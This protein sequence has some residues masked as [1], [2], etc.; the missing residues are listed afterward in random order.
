ME[1]SELVSLTKSAAGLVSLITVCLMCVSWFYYQRLA[2]ELFFGIGRDRGLTKWAIQRKLLVGDIGDLT[3][4]QV[5]AYRFSRRLFLC[6]LS[7]FAGL[8]AFAISMFWL[9][10]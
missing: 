3:D 8:C 10:N 6:G 1:T 9:T 5:K 7:S 2:E 4:D